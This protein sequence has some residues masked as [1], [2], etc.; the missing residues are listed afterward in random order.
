MKTT[1]TIPSQSKDQKVTKI[2]MNFDHNPKVINVEI[3]DPNRGFV[4][5]Q[6]DITDEWAGA[7][8]ANK[9]IITTFF[10]IVSKMALNQLNSPEGI[11]I[12]NN[13]IT[14]EMFEVNP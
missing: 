3:Q 13:D 14:G 11:V 12:D 7:S 1:V 2:T 10:R 5:E 4:T 9:N 8:A 6:V